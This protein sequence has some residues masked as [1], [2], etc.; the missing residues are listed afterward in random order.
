MSQ[1]ATL[2]PVSGGL[3]RS[4]SWDE[5]VDRHGARVFRLAYR[6]CGNRAD[7]EDLTQDVFVKVFRSLDT[8][9]PG[10][11]EGWL[12]RITTTL[13]LDRARRRAR[14]RFDLLGDRSEATVLGR[15]PAPEQVSFEG[16]FDPDVERALDALAPQFRAAVVLCDIEGLTYEEVADVLGLKLGPVRWGID[17]GGARLRH[18]VRLRVREPASGRRRYRGARWETM[19]GGRTRAPVIPIRRTPRPH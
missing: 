2:D 6:L 5:I 18:A 4:A 10:T 14:I 1:S 13:F 8:Y 3:D 16:V 15:I 19:P 9:T 12:P 7:A 17:R 11:F